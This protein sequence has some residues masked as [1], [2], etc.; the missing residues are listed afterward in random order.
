MRSLPVDRVPST[1]VPRRSRRSSSKG[2]DQ[3]GE[4]TKHDAGVILVV[5]I[6]L[7]VLLGVPAPWD[8]L[9][10]I[11]GC[12]LEVGEVIVLRRWS[13]RIDRRT[14]PTTGAA[15]MLGELARVVEPCRPLGM[16]ELNGELWRAR[17]DEGADPGETVEVKAIEKLTLIV[18]RQ[19]AIVTTG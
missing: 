6:L 5:T 19:P 7:V 12:L 3:A 16:V 8:A 1:T 17:C 15:A 4:P 11:A 18:S 9:L 10:I 14:R 13:K 2:D